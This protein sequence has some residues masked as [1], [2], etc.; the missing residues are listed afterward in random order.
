MIRRGKIARLPGTVR[1]ELNQ[2]L[3]R[4]DSGP[5]L[6]EWLNS[7]PETQKVVTEEFGG[8]AITEQ[9]LSDWRQGGYRDWERQQESRE[10]V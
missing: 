8:N 2:R 3:Q 6:V 1:E 10:W 4:A 5:L 9:N 7:L